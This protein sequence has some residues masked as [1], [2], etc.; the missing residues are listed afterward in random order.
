MT[1]NNSQTSFPFPFLE[2]FFLFFFCFCF[3]FC[4]KE[5]GAFNLLLF[6]LFFDTERDFGIIIII[7]FVL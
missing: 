1:W 5:R 7:S 4:E 2:S 6:G 3:C